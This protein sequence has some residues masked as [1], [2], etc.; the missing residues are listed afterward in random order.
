MCN[1]MSKI[2]VELSIVAIEINN[3]VLDL[4]MCNSLA[5]R[6]INVY[7]CERRALC[8]ESCDKLV[9]AIEVRR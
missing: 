6:Y 5:D 1:A 8:S 9:H 2:A 4:F 3:S 7:A